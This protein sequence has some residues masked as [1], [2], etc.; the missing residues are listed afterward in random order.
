M[1][2]WLLGVAIL[3]LAVGLLVATVQAKK[4]KEVKTHMPPDLGIRKPAVAGM[5][6]PA[7]PE[8]L[9]KMMAR[10]FENAKKP[11]IPGEIVGLVSPHAGFQYS[12]LIAA[13]SYKQVEGKHYDVVFVVA[14]SHHEYFRGASVFTGEGYETPLGLVPVDRETAAELLAT[15]K[16]FHAGWEGHRQEHSLEAQLPFLQ[17]ALGSFKMVPIVMAERDWDTCRRVGEGI[18]KVARGKHVLLVASSDLYHGYSY[19]ECNAT[20][21]RT[22][23]AIEKFDAH[24]F[25]RGLNRG[26]YQACGGG[27]IT[28]VMVAAREL[29]ADKAKV[30]AHTTS[31]DVT[32]RKS[33]YIV[34]YGSVVFYKENK[35]MGSKTEKVGVD[36]GLSKEDK[37]TLLTIAKKTIEARVKGQPFPKFEVTS[38]HLLEKRGA[39]VTIN[40]H[41]MLRGCIGYVLPVKPLWETVMEVAESAAL[42]DPRFPPVTPD[43]LPDLEIEISVLTVPREIHDIHEIQVGKHGI[44]IERGF[45]SGLLLPQVATEYGWDRE[46]FLDHT[47]QKAGMPPGCWRDRSTVIKIFSAEVFSE[48]DV[49]E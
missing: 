5:W 2:R 18:A 3:G 6:Y 45:N 25:N 7:D 36:L 48:K 38:P 24:A 31:G 16:I 43:E 23:Q 42:R 13:H 49:D 12:G 34:G 32:G 4:R 39:F 1:K 46:T 35:D 40:K 21:R 22:L 11:A 20:D 19:D 14:P 10:F 27:P 28:A 33:G 9:H 26:E 47:C 15:D 30:I 8:E 29:G 44:I 17:T 41:G 37:K